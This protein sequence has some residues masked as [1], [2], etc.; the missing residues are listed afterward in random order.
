MS[1]KELI[2]WYQVNRASLP[3]EEFDL[4]EYLKVS[5]PE[6]FYARLDS[7]LEEYPEIKGRQKFIDLIRRLKIF[8]ESKN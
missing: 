3:M 7:D 6:T 8:V 4:S 5:D 2:E 1:P